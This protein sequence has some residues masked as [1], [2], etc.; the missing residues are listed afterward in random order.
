MTSSERLQ[1]ALAHKE[2]DRV[3]LDLGGIV[4]GITLYAH[5]NLCKF[6]GIQE[7]ETLV[8]RVQYLAKPASTILEQFDID[9]R[10]VYDVIPYQVWSHD[11]EGTTWKDSWGVE[12]RFTGLYYDMTSHPLAKVSSLEELKKYVPPEPSIDFF[13]KARSEAEVLKSSGKAVIINCI[14]S[15]FEFAW[16]LR[17]FAQFMM[18]LVFQPG[19]ACSIMDIMLDFQL[20]QFNLLLQEA[21]TLIDLVLVG[22]DLATQNSPLISIEMY[23]KYVKPRQKKLYEFI[24]TK[25]SAPLLY[26]SCGAIADFLEDLVEIGI[27]VIN[28]VQVSARSMDPKWLK[29]NFGEALSFWGGID[30]QRVLP[31]GTPEEVR[32]E[33]R[34][35]IDELAPGGGYVLCAVHNIQAD[36]PP[37]NIVAMYEEALSYGTY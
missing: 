19:L 26:H 23:R 10:Y 5:R 30:T 24:K 36:V 9:T 27:E 35:R 1:T 11:T 3:P 37:Q 14:G 6:L 21:G 25:T 8:D 34:R 15:C 32:E 2:P 29:K 16:Y 33:V 28:P 18:D 7:E 4:S 17:G 20:Q 22:D 12:R 13:K 31:F